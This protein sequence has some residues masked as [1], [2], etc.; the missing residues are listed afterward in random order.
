MK[1]YFSSPI[2]L[3]TAYVIFSKK[4]TKAIFVLPHNRGNEGTKDHQKLTKQ[5]NSIS[6]NIAR[7]LEIEYF[8]MQFSDYLLIEPEVI[9]SS[10]AINQNCAKGIIINGSDSYCIFGFAHYLRFTRTKLKLER[11]FLRNFKVH[12][13]ATLYSYNRF[14][15]SV[16]SSHELIDQVKV[17]KLLDEVAPIVLTELSQKVTEVINRDCILVI[18][19]I[20]KYSGIDFTLKFMKRVE[21]IAEESNL[22]VFIKPHRN[23]SRTY[24]DVFLN[25]R[26]LL[27]EKLDLRYIPVEFFFTLSHVKSIV[28]VPSSSLALAIGIPTQV[29]VPKNNHLFRKSFLDQLPFL[30]SIG[31]EYESI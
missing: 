26:L 29:L 13:A 10:L 19:P 16:N 31:L 14:A 2:A 4:L 15:K 7:A 27:G 22:R 18:P 1:L 25:R 20:S 3:I 6:Q 17:R 11:L 21:S 5:L 8:E 23:D 12:S 24:L 9:E 28:A 30:Q